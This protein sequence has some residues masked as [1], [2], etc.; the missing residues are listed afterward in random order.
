[1]IIS[2][3]VRVNKGGELIVRGLEFEEE[4]V[5]RV[6]ISCWGIGEKDGAIKFVGVQ[7]VRKRLK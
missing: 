3:Y 2:K 6:I 5:Y 4:K 7:V 1:M